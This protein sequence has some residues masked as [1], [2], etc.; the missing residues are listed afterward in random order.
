[1]TIISAPS[2]VAN[3]NRV[4]LGDAEIDVVFGIEDRDIERVSV[5]VMGA[6]AR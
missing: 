2:A 5:A 4:P 1:M 6:M 3:S